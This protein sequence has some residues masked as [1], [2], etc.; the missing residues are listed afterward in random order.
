MSEPAALALVGCGSI[1][2]VH[3]DALA[4]LWEAGYRRFRI[5]ATCDAD[6]DRAAAFAERVGGFQGT[7]PAA[8]TSLERLLSSGT[9]QAVDLSVPHDLH[10]SLACACFE[11]GCHVTIEKPLGIT[12]RAARRILESAEAAGRVLQVAENYRRERIH[13]AVHWA[14]RQGWIGEPRLL[15]WID[16]VE[17]L[18]H[19]GWR[20]ELARAGGGWVLDGGVHFADLFRY[21]VGE[22]DRV[23]A[24]SRA[25]HPFRHPEG[26]RDGER[27]GVDVED[28]VVAWFEFENGAVGQWT[29]CSVAPGRETHARILYGSE[30][31]ISWETGLQTADRTLNPRELVETHAESLSAEERERLFPMGI[32]NSFALE[33]KEFIDAVLDGTPVEVDGREGY[34][35]EAVCMALY[36]SAAC[37]RPVRVGDVADLQ[38]ETYQRPLNESLG[39][40]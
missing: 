25:L 26:R 11:A 10:H 37:G 6:P 13:R 35:D 36:E 2:G 31:S 22:I 7:R 8:E 18:W 30:G 23:S 34:R 21:H 24:V 1:M 12:L 32:D 5:V 14:I 15:F 16:A 29:S 38:V 39:L 28:T 19:W 27:I 33:L 40:T 4:A 20:E 9:V 17:R 3:L